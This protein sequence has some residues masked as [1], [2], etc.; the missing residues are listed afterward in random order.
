M[1][2]VKA[3]NSISDFNKH[4]FEAKSELPDETQQM[5]NPEPRLGTA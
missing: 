4:H 3:L 5:S 2:S 1:A